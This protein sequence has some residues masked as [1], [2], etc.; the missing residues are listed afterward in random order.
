M[1]KYILISILSVGL[2][3]LF[4]FINKDKYPD[5]LKKEYVEIFKAEFIKEMNSKSLIMDLE[6]KFHPLFDKVNTVDVQ[7]NSEHGY[8]YLVIG[9]KDNKEKVEMLKI[10][11]SD[12]EN[13]SYTYIDFTNI[14]INSSTEYCRSGNG[15]PFPPV[16]Q[17][18]CLPRTN[19]CLGILCGIRSGNSCHIY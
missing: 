8:Y 11:K 9:K 10:N 3:S 12:F 14:N 6:S 17:G 7:F 18:G 4:S 5:S 19:N 13:N 16:C 2:L 15:Y 1:K